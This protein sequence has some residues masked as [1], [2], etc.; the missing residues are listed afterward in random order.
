MICGTLS[1]HVASRKA[2]KERT[3]QKLVD[4]TL[5]V[6]YRDGR[7][8]LTTG[9]IAEAAGVA[10]PTFYVHF[11]DMEDAL[12]QAADAVAQKLLQRLKSYRSELGMGAPFDLVRGAYAASVKALVREPKMAELFLRHR[13]DAGSPLGKRWSEITDRARADLKADMEKWGLGTSVDVDFYAELIVGMTLATVEGLLDGRIAETD[14][15]LD[16]LATFTM[17]GFEKA[18][19]QK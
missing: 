13:R 16:E 4:A 5:K 1:G 6:L 17:G 9:R 8:A 12:T 11:S 19:Q 14:A 2:S 3:H 15:A 7:S 18:L 10:Q